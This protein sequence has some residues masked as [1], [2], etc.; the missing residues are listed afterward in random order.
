MATPLYE[1]RI[2]LIFAFLTHPTEGEGEVY[3]KQTQSNYFIVHIWN[4]HGI[5]E[6]EILKSVAK[7]FI[8]R[9]KGEQ[10][11]SFIGP[12]ANLED[13]KQ[14]CHYL[15]NE[16]KI[17]KLTLFSRD[18]YNRAIEEVNSKDELN[19]FFAQAGEVIENVHRTAKKSFFDRVFVP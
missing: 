19:S 5:V 9:L 10:F 3:S 17:N 7:D 11:R 14:F 15:M 16:L 2:N 8:G 18:E 13:L 1:E 4:D 6:H 12:F